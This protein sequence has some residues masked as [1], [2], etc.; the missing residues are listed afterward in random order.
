MRVK[1]LLAS[2]LCCF[3]F[4][5]I[6]QNINDAKKL[7]NDG[8]YEKAKSAFQKLVKASPSSSVNN[9]WYGMACMKTGDYVN[10]EKYLKNA[11]KRRYSEAYR[12]LGE[13]YSYTYDFDKSLEQYDQ[14]VT[15]ME[16]SKKTKTAEQYRTEMDR[17][18]HAESMLRGVEMVNVID[19]VVLDKKDFLSFYKLGKSGSLS[20]Y[21]DFFKGSDE[22]YGVVYCTQLGNTII[23]GDRNQDGG[24][25]LYK[26]YF[27]GSSWS[28]R[29][30]LPDVVNK[31]TF[32]NYPFMMSDGLTIYYA[33]QCD[34]S[35]GGYD[36]FVTAYNT[37]TDSYMQPENI[38]MPFN[39]VF[40]DYMLAIDEDNDLGWFASDRYQPQGKVCIYVF[41]PNDRKET[42]DPNNTDPS[43]L[44]KA[45]S[46]LGF[47]DVQPS[48][49]VASNG[50]E[51][52]KAVLSDENVTKARDFE[53]VIDDNRIYTSIYDF[54]SK[55]AQVFFKQWQQ[56]C[57]DLEQMEQKLDDARVVYHNSDAAKRKQMTNSI[58]DMEKR[59]LDMKNEI[60]DLEVM[61]RNTEINKKL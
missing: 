31:G 56:K 39:S 29:E 48:K 8:E 1:Y 55:D 50:L 12:G 40:N 34:E 6:A 2:T 10:A 28:R 20:Y 36:I 49:D 53:F 38:G 60:H 15:Q 19:S 54:M 18:E 25:D 43:V 61:V 4:S 5:G 11:A 47:H 26:S 57:S 46:L 44:K 52:L 3:F 7:Y 35:I 33:S 58:L 27:D 22:H 24:M 17:M 45:A 14:Y 37:N 13:L 9:Y 30:R 51:R 32:Q 41:V 16:K 59:V 23:Y 42:Y 21:N